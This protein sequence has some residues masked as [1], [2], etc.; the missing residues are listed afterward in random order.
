MSRK[1]RRARYATSRW[2]L[3]AGRRF[4]GAGLWAWGSQ[5][6]DA[7]GGQDGD[8]DEASSESDVMS[9]E[10]VALGAT[11]GGSGVNVT[12]SSRLMSRQ[13]VPAQE[14]G[15]SVQR[16]L[17]WRKN[18]VRQAHKRRKP[19]SDRRAA[20]RIQL[21]YERGACGAGKGAWQENAEQAQR[22]GRAAVGTGLGVKMPQIER[23]RQRAPAAYWSLEP[24]T[25]GFSLRMNDCQCDVQRVMKRNVA[26]VEYA[27]PRAASIMANRSLS[28]AFLWIRH[29]KVRSDNGDERLVFIPAIHACFTAL[30]RG[31]RRTR[32]GMG[33][34][35][36]PGTFPRETY[37]WTD[38]GIGDFSSYQ[39]GV[40]WLRYFCV[41]RFTGQRET[42]KCTSTLLKL[43][44][45][46]N[47]VSVT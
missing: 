26:A 36:R 20:G 21:A 5:I 22:D 28:V 35:V 7:A 44:K 14:V 10:S 11:S 33:K 47:S 34:V 39:I 29:P 30:Q 24:R 23:A 15:W 40:G 3:R 13:L 19:A 38:T 41:G 31:H 18:S 17:A 43:R 27:V 8:G 25:S 6:G 4:Q 9:G 45:S 32:G 12:E 16:E 46:V 1:K 42:D 2:V 37:R